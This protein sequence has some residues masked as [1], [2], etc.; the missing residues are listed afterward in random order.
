MYR[1]RK[2]KG[3]KR[4]NLTIYINISL[5]IDIFILWSS[6]TRLISWRSVSSEAQDTSDFLLKCS[7]TVLRTPL[8]N[9]SPCLW[10]TRLYEFL[11]KTI[12]QISISRAFFSPIEL[13]K[14]QRRCILFVDF[15]DCTLE[16]PPNILCLRAVNCNVVAKGFNLK[17]ALGW[18][19]LFLLLQKKKKLLKFT[20]FFLLSTE[21][22]SD[23]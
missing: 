23:L 16:L 8:Y 18:H 7:E 1:T 9:K 6:Q 14:A 2:P 22:L 12:S 17:F 19:G 21:I 10:S 15:F 20:R 5:I 3:E 13:F 4:K 11:G